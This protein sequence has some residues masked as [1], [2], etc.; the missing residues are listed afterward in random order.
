MDFQRASRGTVQSQASD[1]Y[2]LGHWW[3]KVPTIARRTP[4][5]VRHNALSGHYQFLL[6]LRGSIEVDWEGQV[7]SYG[8]SAVT[9]LAT[10][11][12]LDMSMSPCE[13]ISLRL[14]RSAIDERIRLTVPFCAAIAGN[15]GL[16]RV[17][18]SMIYN[19]HKERT[20]LTESQFDGVCDQ[21]AAL[22]CMIAE[23]DR[24]TV[25]ADHPGMVSARVRRY[26]RKHAGSPTLTIQQ[27]GA[28]LGWSTRQ[29]QASLQENQTTYR[30]LVQD[31][32]LEIA[33]ERLASPAGRQYSIADVAASCGLSP[34]RLSVIFKSRYGESPREYKM[35]T[36]L[37][38][39]S[40][41]LG[42]SSV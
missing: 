35:R 25:A 6:L 31:A 16:G 41:S 11:L 27:V 14:P 39:P 34:G 33:R 36:A 12:P 18:A 23:G 4:G 21:I 3:A 15:K 42:H 37:S 9:T 28:D 29:I 32:R 7:E 19:L 26:I 24:S 1:S 2:L 40:V 10:D 17:A 20:N 8:S 5:H 38:S 22:L 30:D 13:F